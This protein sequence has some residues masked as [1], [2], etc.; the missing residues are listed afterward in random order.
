MEKNKAYKAFDPEKVERGE[1]GL[2]KVGDG[3]VRTL[4]DG[5]YCAVSGFFF[6]IVEGKY[7]VLAN[8]R[9][10]GTPD[11]QDCWCCPCGFLERG[12]D[13]KG[14]IIRETKEECMIDIPRDKIREVHTE[15]D[16]EICNNGNVTIRHTGFLGKQNQIFLDTPL[17]EWDAGL[18]GEKNEVA[19][20]RWIP[21][22]DIG[23]YRWAFNHLQ[24]IRQYAPPLWLRKIIEIYFSLF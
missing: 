14:G 8:L 12:E 7:S 18:G 16:P 10:S 21:V 9:G 19:D 4:Y 2:W 3:D 24:T 13:A 23:K 6:A 1:D 22:D 5:R 20:I 17:D 15:T 11:Y